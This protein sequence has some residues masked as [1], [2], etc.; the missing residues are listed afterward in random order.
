MLVSFHGGG[1]TTGSGNGPM[2]DGANLA[3]FGDVVVV[4]VNH[5]LAAFGYLHLAGL[6]GAPATSPT[7]A[8]SASPTWSPR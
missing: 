3:Q 2:Y 1:W 4:T 7:P 5:R 8:R 6:A